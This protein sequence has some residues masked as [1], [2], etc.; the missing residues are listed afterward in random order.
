MNAEQS[1]KN[2]RGT[3]VQIL[4]QVSTLAGF[5]L[6]RPRP[7]RSVGWWWAWCRLAWWG[8]RQR[9]WRIHRAQA[10]SNPGGHRGGWWGKHPVPPPLL[11]PS[12]PVRKRKG[13]AHAAAP[14]AVVGRG[15]CQSQSR[16]RLSS[17]RWS[18]GWLGEGRRWTLPYLQWKCNSLLAPNEP[19]QYNTATVTGCSECAGTSLVLDYFAVPKYLK[20]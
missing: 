14:A 12:Q 10:Q 16:G 19:H 3:S 1:R 13:K 2:R 18:W 17:G 5:F 20:R 7:Q 11:P 8:A 15:W 6:Y 4:L 9:G